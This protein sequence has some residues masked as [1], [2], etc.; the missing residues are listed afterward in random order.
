MYTDRKNPKSDLHK[1]YMVFLEAGLI[2]VLVIVII[3]MKVDLNPGG[4]EVRPHRRTGSGG[5][6]R[7]C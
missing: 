5:N 2:A 7:E 4:Q 6:E 3:A 1:Y